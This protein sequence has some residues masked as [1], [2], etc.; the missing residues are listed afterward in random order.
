MDLEP[1]LLVH[2]LGSN[3]TY[4]TADGIVVFSNFSGVETN[5][6]KLKLD[7]G[8]GR[9]LSFEFRKSDLEFK[10]SS[11]PGALAR[12]RQE[13]ASRTQAYQQI[14]LPEGNP[15]LL[16]SALAIFG[17]DLIRW[18]SRL[19]T[20]HSPAKLV[21]LHWLADKADLTH[22][23]SPF[24]RL[25]EP[26]PDSTFL[27][28]AAQADSE[29]A[30][31][32]GGMRMIG[33]CLLQKCD[34]ICAHE[35]WP[36]TLLHEAA[37]ACCGNNQYL[38]AEVQRTLD[39]PTTGPLGCLVAMSFQSWL[40]PAA[41]RPNFARSLAT[42]S[43]AGFKQDW[44]T[45]LD[46]RSV[47]GAFLANLIGEFCSTSDTESASLLAGSNPDD[48]AFLLQCLQL[49][50]A[51][52]GK[53]LADV[54]WPAVEQH[55]DKVFQPRLVEGYEQAFQN[56]ETALRRQGNAAEAD[57]VHGEVLALKGKMPVKQPGG[58]DDAP[59]ATGSSSKR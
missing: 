23:V 13:I 31:Q 18:A 16:T 43:P 55:W 6:W 56:V 38:G 8:T 25:F 7:A 53:P 51:S 2:L 37:M 10:L 12:A 36:W 41:S 57:S 28:P 47:L 22:T 50:K 5:D 48:A 44:R 20:N 34:R 26:R 27:I 35:S 52:P 1:A 32:A 9:L 19:Q 21:L 46:D 30:D 58:A 33:V 29:A 54:L 45:L 59:A 11:G 4:S 42:V 14:S 15:A 39:S 24:S 3:S 40:N 17:P 49:A